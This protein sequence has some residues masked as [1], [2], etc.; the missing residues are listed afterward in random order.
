MVKNKMATLLIIVTAMLVSAC[1]SWQQRMLFIGGIG[2]G[3]VVEALPGLVED[4]KERAVEWRRLRQ[5]TSK[6]KAA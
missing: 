1:M 2:F 3:L 4:W 5:F 6:A